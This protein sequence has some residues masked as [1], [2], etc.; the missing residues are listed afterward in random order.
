MVIRNS[1]SHR[2]HGSSCAGG[3]SEILESFLALLGLAVKI[4]ARH[5]VAVL[6]QLLVLLFLKLCLIEFVCMLICVQVNVGGA[7]S[8]RYNIVSST[9]SALAES[10]L[11][12]NNF[13]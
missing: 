8:E 11:N 4:L 1:K 9:M 2:V 10:G 3:R 12:F 13:T 5:V 6:F 7:T